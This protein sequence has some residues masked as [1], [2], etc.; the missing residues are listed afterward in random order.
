M[1]GKVRMMTTLGR[2][3]DGIIRAFQ[4]DRVVSTEAD[5]V[6]ALTSKNVGTIRLANDIVV[7]KPITLNGT[8]N[9]IIDGGGRFGLRVG[10]KNADNCMFQLASNTV[11]DLI[12][13]GV[14]F[15]AN[16]ASVFCG[17]GAATILNNFRFDN[18][19]LDGVLFAP[20]SG[21]FTINN[22]SL[23]VRN[24][25]FPGSSDGIGDF[26][27][28]RSYDDIGDGSLYQL[29]TDDKTGL[30]LAAGT[31]TLDGKTTAMVRADPPGVYDRGIFYISS[32]DGV[33]MQTANQ[34]CANLPHGKRQRR[35]PGNRR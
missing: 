22:I 21:Y 16:G 8:Y 12:F 31:G 15:H 28:V 18:V 13:S 33:Y 1:N 19:D 30:F 10:R 32:P 17:D 4:T 20:L 6:V 3:R 24:R 35:R 5:F 7:R 14:I 2:F 26:T 29:K 27:G 11:S 23:N 25:V 34:C 9:T